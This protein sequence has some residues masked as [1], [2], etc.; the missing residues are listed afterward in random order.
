[1]QLTVCR[2]YNLYTPSSDNSALLK[3]EIMKK[4]LFII[5]IVLIIFA[6]I[7]IIASEYENIT[8]ERIS[9]I[10]IDYSC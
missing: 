4:I 1:M 3:G 10:T 7:R 9:Y 8:R 6:F 2:N 5:L